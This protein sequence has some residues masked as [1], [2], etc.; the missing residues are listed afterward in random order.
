[1][2][3]LDGWTPDRQS[4]NLEVQ[5]TPEQYDKIRPHRQA[6]AFWDQY[7][8]WPGGDL[9]PLNEVRTE[10]TGEHTDLVCSGCVEILLRYINQV[11]KDYEKQNP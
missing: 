3:L 5:M 6:L 10:L 8:T 11:V 2:G 4:N 1:M 7:R 9:R